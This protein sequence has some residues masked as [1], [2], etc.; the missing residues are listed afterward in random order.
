MGLHPRIAWIT[1]GVLIIGGAILIGLA[2]YVAG[3]QIHHT[4]AAVASL[5]LSI[6]ARTAG[7]NI[8]P[9]EAMTPAAIS[10]LILLMF[11]GGCPAGTAG[12]V[13]TTAFAV[14]LLNVRRIV[15]GRRDV[16]A[17]GRRLPEE[18]V[19]RAM[20]VMILS[21]GWIGTGTTLLALL[22]PH[23]PLSALVFEVVSALST[24]GLSRGVTPELGAVAKGVI[25]LTMFA[26]R[27]G[28]L[29]FVFA[30]LGR[31]KP[32]PYRVPEEN[33]YVT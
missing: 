30:F 7:F 32:T 33:I 18:V 29:Y 14:A 3:R 16:E 20:A 27:I 11:I 22:E 9:V 10:V 2:E 23:V 19:S 4:P 17:F 26:G 8:S 6:T 1:T 12:G 15:L 28:L 5:F 25:I 24:V 31:P 21:V 13:R